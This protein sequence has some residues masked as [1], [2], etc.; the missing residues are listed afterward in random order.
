MP[1]A[2]LS[3]LQNYSRFVAEL[4]SN[5]HLKSSTLV[6][7]PI[8]KY[9]GT[10]EGEIFFEQGYRLRIREDL[11]FEASLIVSYGYEVYQDNEKLYWYDDFPHPHNPTLASTH[12]HHKHIPP[13]IK[14]NRIPAPQISFEYPN[15]PVLIQE[16]QELLAQK[17]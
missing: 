10:A 13:N 5:S 11:D 16:I 9:T 17:S 6:I 7:W 12:P 2:P 14:R 4:L 8:S 3:S 1:D 15:L